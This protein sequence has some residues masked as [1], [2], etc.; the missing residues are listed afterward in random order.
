MEDWACLKV[1]APGELPPASC[2]TPGG[3]RSPECLPQPGGVDLCHYHR[4]QGELCA[5]GIVSGAQRGSP[6]RAPPGLPWGGGQWNSVPVLISKEP[7]SPVRACVP[8]QRGMGRW[9]GRWGGAG[10]PGWPVG[11]P[12]AAGRQ[13]AEPGGQRALFWGCQPLDCRCSWACTASVSA[14]SVPVAHPILGSPGPVGGDPV[15]M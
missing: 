2:S 11:T 12:W 5:S 14:R 3:R 9:G 10:A 7:A 4:P 1:Q 15:R 6:A 8:F 13:D